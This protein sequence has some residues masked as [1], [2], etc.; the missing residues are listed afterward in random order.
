MADLSIKLKTEADSASFNSS[1]KKLESQ[2][3]PIKLRIEATTGVSGLVGKSAKESSILFKQFDQASTAAQD[4]QVKLN[5]LKTTGGLTQKQFKN[6]STELTTLKSD[7]ASGKISVKEFNDGMH[8]LKNRVS[9]ASTSTKAMGQSILEIIG[10]FTK[11]YLI[12]GLVTGVISLFKSAISTVIELDTAMVELSKVFDGT[13]E[14]LESV[15]KRAYEIADALSSTGLEVIDA[16]TE[17]KRMGY[18]IDES[19]DLAEVAIMMTNVAEGITNTGD[20]A[21]IL[22]SILKG[23]GTEIKYV[24]SLLDRLNE[25]SNNNAISFDALANMLQ[26]SA[27]TMSVLGNNLDETIGLL[28]GAF[29][30]IQDERVAKGLTT[31]GLRIAGLSEDM[32]SLAGFS[33][34]ATE[35]LEKYAGISVFDKETGQLRNTYSILKDLAGVWDN[36]NATEQSVVVNKLAGK[37]RADIATAILENWEEVDKAVQDASNSMGSAQKEYSKY[38]NSVNA[39]TKKLKNSIQKLAQT[40]IT[41]DTI[42]TIIDGIAGLIEFLDSLGV[43]LLDLAKIAAITYATISLLMGNI[44]GAV[45]GTA[46]LAAIIVFEETALNHAQKEATESA[47]TATKSYAD[48]A[49]SYETAAD[50]MGDYDKALYSMGAKQKTLI[51]ILEEKIEAMKKEQEA[52][53]RE[54]ELNEKLLAVEKARQEL[55]EAKKNKIRVFRAGIGFT[56]ESD[57]TEVQSA[58]ESLQESIDALSEYKYNTALDRAEEFMDELS[59]ILS[60][61][62][63]TVGW[64]ELFDNFED[65]IGSEFESFLE[66]S[67]KFVENFNSEIGDTNSKISIGTDEHNASGDIN[68]KGGATWVGEHGPEIV[69]LPQ[70]SE[71]LSH[72]KSMKLTSM[73]NNPNKFINGVNGGLTLQFNGPLEFP[74]VRTAEDASGFIDAVISVGNSRVPKYS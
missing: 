5:N 23:S 62:D 16:T 2:V 69:N 4:F 43:T 68:F 31:I 51:G 34:E 49:E 63:M 53:E 6:F 3:S 38:L 50:K 60:G 47:N 54:E 44:V 73:V 7:F 24:Y 15:K 58:Q 13:D 35:A 61:D 52:L 55:A 72:N 48:L 21:N 45:K 30:V 10:K 64:E 39:K 14:E 26:D 67:K 46:A 66:M 41:S 36:L 18:T 37:Q 11:W 71:I 8:D 12:S 40:L 70:G 1:I 57:T 25:V 29:S 59:E 19:L 42:K 32:D 17:F 33:N 74:N 28:T 9:E 56:Y 65:L 22:I 20:A 27:S